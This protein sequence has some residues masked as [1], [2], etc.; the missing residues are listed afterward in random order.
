MAN[1]VCCDETN[2]FRN[3]LF[4]IGAPLLI[5]LVMCLY[6]FQVFNELK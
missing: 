3:Y 1:D 2:A 4:Q 5:V 6:C